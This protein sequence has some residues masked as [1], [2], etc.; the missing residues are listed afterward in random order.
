MA[1]PVQILVEGREDVS[2]TCAILGISRNECANERCQVTAVGGK[3][4]FE[5]VLKG[6]KAATSPSSFLRTGLEK[7]VLVVDADEDEDQT[8]KNLTAQLTRAGYPLPSSS[9]SLAT[10][11]ESTF[12]FQTEFVLLPGGNR[13]GAMEDLVLTALASGQGLVLADKYLADVCRAGLDHHATLGP[14]AAK[15]FIGSEPSTKGRIQAL[16]S[17]FSKENY[18]LLGMAFDDGIIDANA[19]EFAAFRERLRAL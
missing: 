6:W 10:P 17:Q 15:H 19:E 18:K 14:G 13:P 4:K 7:L 9:S 3:S 1:R 8:R 2:I 12:T 16:L 5:Q 11:T